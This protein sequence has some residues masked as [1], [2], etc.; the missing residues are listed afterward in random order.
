MQIALVDRFWCEEQF[1]DDEFKPIDTTNEGEKWPKYFSDY[2]INK[3][4]RVPSQ[5]WL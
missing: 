2:V 1:A 5:T 4:D 3:R